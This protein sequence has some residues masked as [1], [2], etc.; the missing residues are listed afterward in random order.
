MGV[1]SDLTA[2]V[3]NDEYY[4]LAL[5]YNGAALN[6][7]GYTV[8]AYLKATRLTPDADAVGLRLRQRPDHHQRARWPRHVGY[9]AREP[10][11]PDDRVVPRRRHRRLP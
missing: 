10:A 3:G 5:T 4:Y 9:P 8:K 7:T 1:Q 2:I 11:E 6:L